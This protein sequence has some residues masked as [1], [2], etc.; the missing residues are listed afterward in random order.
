MVF[1][2]RVQ[3]G[4]FW[5]F[6]AIFLLFGV[7]ALSMWLCHRFGKKFAY[8]YI[9]II[10][11]ANFA[12]HFCK[13]FLPNY[14]TR[15]PDSLSDSF[16]PNLCAVLISISPFVFHWG[17]KYLK[18]YM[19]YLGIISGVAVY[20]VPTGAMRMDIPDMEYVFETTRFYLCHWPLVVCGL[21]MVEQGFHKLDW[22]R[23]WAMPIM[24]CGILALICLHVIVCGPLLKLQGFPHEWVG[25]NGILYRAPIGV[26]Y[27]NQSMQ[28]GP[29][30]GVDKIFGWAYPYLI[31]F[32]M[33]Y[34]VDGTLYFTPVIWIA[35][36]IAILTALFAPLMAAPFEHRQMRLDLI[37]LSQKRKMK[38]L[39]K[40][41]SR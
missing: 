3:L 4:N 41:K 8:W 16:F 22:K 6:L 7:T 17:N 1:L 31:P 33:T 18:D 9:A 23:L 13:Q 10:L 15:W 26:E 37:A 35:P 36:F 21:L 29:Q 5:Y 32:L 11:W 25:E 34:K 20:F 2:A 14:Y 24:Y 27:S 30:L 12:L 38:R 19:Y 28:F 40:M 39:A